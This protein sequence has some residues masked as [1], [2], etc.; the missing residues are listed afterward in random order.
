[1]T[2]KPIAPI[3]RAWQR[4]TRF[5]TAVLPIADDPFWP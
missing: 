2:W 1:L 4:M 3:A 5:S